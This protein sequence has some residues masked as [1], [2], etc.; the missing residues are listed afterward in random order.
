MS[1]VLRRA[2]I[3]VLGSHLEAGLG[4]SPLRT[5]HP[6]QQHAFPCGGRTGTSVAIDQELL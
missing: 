5:S 1:W 2:A 6:R 3:E 4:T